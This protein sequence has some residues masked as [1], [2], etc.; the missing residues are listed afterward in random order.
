MKKSE[1]IKLAKA[2]KMA[3]LRSRIK[4]IQKQV[5][6]SPKPERRLRSEAVRILGL[7]DN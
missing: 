6:M 1:I 7:L 4:A 3:E 5:T 2:G